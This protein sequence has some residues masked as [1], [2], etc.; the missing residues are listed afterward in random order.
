MTK[1]IFKRILSLCLVFALITA[2]ALTMVSCDKKTDATDGTKGTLPTVTEGTETTASEAIGT[3]TLTVTFADG[4]EQTKDYHYYEEG[5]LGSF[6]TENGIAEGEDGQYG[7]YI[8]TVLGQT[9]EYETDG[10]YWAFYVDGEYAMTGVSDTDLTD[11]ACYQ[12]KAE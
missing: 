10:S 6:L 1:A 11:G 8:K 12:L 3:F 2:M 5:D 7:L 4:S 9:H